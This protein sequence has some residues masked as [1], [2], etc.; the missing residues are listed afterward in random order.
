M[1]LIYVALGGAL[2]ALARYGVSVLLP[3]GTLIVN[4]LGAFLALFVIT[5]FAEN[6]ITGRSIRLF[7]LVGFLGAFTTFS[8]YTAELI[9]MFREG[10][11]M[12]AAVHI[13]LNNILSI[14]A[15]L[16]GIFIAKKASEYLL[17]GSV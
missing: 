15:G 6:I 8:A 9:A 14:L 17:L 1:E 4:V 11:H 10:L 2:G 13:A 7:T 16:L 3:N 12:K 5:M